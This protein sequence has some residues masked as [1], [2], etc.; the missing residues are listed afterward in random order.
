METRVKDKILIVEDVS[1]IRDLLDVTLRFK[2]YTVQTAGNGQEALNLIRSEPPALVISDIL[3]PKMDGFSLVQRLRLEKNTRDIPI[4]MISATYVSSEDREFALRLGAVR[5]LEKPVDTDEFLQVVNDC[6]T[7]E[8]HSLPDPLNDSD[9]YAGY[10][11]R[12]EIKLAQKENQI[13]RAERLLRSLEEDQKPAFRAVL[14]EEIH[15]RNSI[16]N[17]L[18]TVRARV[19]DTGTQPRFWGEA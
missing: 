6:L 13:S 19:L 5:F 2:G 1:N 17:E 15:F 9:F 11:T 8:K 18:T 14:E 3:M 10:V 4:I 16:L 7:A 12:L